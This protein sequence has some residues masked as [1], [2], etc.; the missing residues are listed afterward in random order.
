MRQ[1][2]KI[3]IFVGGAL[4]V[5]A[6]FIFIVGDLTVIFHKPG[7]P[8]YAVFDSV[9]G[10]ERNAAVRLAGVK[11][12]YVKDIRLEGNRAQ[13]LMNIHPGIQVPRDSRATLAALGLLGEK[14][15]E[16][17][18][19]E[20]EGYCQPG[21]T[22]AGLPAVSFDQM[23]SLLLSIGNEVKEMGE[24]L[25]GMI[26]SE[27]SRT[28]FKKTLHNLSSLTSDLK[29]ILGTNKQEISRTLETPSRAFQK[30]EQRIDEV[31]QN[32]DELI[33][34]LTDTVEENRE[35]IKVN[36]K[37]VNQVLLKTEESLKLLNES[38]HRVNKGEGT[39]GKLIHQP[40]LYD[41]AQETVSGV[42]K[43]MHSL[44]DLRFSMGIRAGYY[45]ES[46]LLKTTLDLR[47]W[48]DSDKYLMA[49][50]IQDPWQEKF[51]YS[52]QGGIRWGGFTTR[53]GVLESKMG[54]GLDYYVFQDRLRFSLEAFDFNRHPRPHL[55]LWTQCS[56]TKYF[57]ILLG[58]DDFTL[59]PE[60]EVFFGFGLGLE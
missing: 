46:E 14:Y 9:S 24:N 50:I 17:I 23:G 33:L 12:G 37:N 8:L 21:E 7:Y 28:N 56:L 6:V 52:A 48:P 15:V 2:L 31:S 27:E 5:L 13:V 19:G 36:L 1:D 47:L 39:M 22:I 11:A 45:G 59:A 25:R 41:Q 16:I 38:L 49:Q 42:Q 44:S 54:A 26:G 10:L 55:R 35:D 20:G 43:M 58:I 60:R 32:L 30:F 4:L 29:D 51:T 34:L 18:P 57:Y 3:G 53:A 40:Q